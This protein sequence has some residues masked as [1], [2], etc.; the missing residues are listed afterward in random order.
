MVDGLVVEDGF[1]AGGVEVTGAVVTVGSVEEGGVVESEVECVGL[2][3]GKQEVVL[4][5]KMGTVVGVSGWKR[6]CN[7]PKKTAP[8]MTKAN[9]AAMALIYG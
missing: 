9:T 6:P 5:C 4:F 1:V 3:V 7:G 8:A 2:V